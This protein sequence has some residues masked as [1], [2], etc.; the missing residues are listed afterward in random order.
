[1]EQDTSRR[2]YLD[3]LERDLAI[4]ATFEDACSI[5]QELLTGPFSATETGEFY[6]IKGLVS[7]TKGVKLTI[8]SKEHA[9]P[10]FHVSYGN[11][12]GLLTIADCS[13]LDGL[14]SN[15]TQNIVYGW[16]KPN[17]PLL[18]QKWNLSRP[19]DCPVG[20]YKE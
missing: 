2:R 12:N 6:E 20:M 13:L 18:I 1:M 14:L 7:V 11:E 10:H 8:N 17:K 16:W 4:C 15:R 19:S 5:L 9:P 3:E